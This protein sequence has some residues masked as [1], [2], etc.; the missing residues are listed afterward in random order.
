M[1]KIQPVF[2]FAATALVFATLNAPAVPPQ[3]LPLVGK[4]DITY[5]G[6]FALPTGTFGTSRFGYGGLGIST[7]NDP[8]T[9]TLSLFFLGYNHNI[10]IIIRAFHVVNYETNH[11]CFALSH[12]D[13]K[14]I[15]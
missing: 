5:L 10:Y 3:E 12:I 4:T 8:A 2:C 6:A 13:F 11:L 1:R 14:T 9:N 15:L 7:Y